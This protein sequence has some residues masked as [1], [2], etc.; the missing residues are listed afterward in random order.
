MSV[1]RL[2]LKEK[3]HQYLN[4]QKIFTDGWNLKY[5]TVVKYQITLCFAI[6]R[7]SVW[8]EMLISIILH[9]GPQILIGFKNVPPNIDKK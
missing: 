1:N 9:I 5:D 3:F 2:L 8:M 6:I 4:F 7:R